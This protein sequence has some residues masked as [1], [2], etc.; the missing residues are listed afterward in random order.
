MTLRPYFTW[1]LL[2]PPPSSL[3]AL[4]FHP[5]QT[6]WSRRCKHIGFISTSVSLHLPIAASL[7]AF[8]RSLHA[9]LI[10]FLLSKI[11]HPTLKDVYV[12]IPRSC[13]YVTIH[14]QRGFENLSCIKGLE[15]ESLSEKDHDGRR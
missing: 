15:M 11:M 8:S 7:H 13:D 14:G 9:T 6:Y 4:S 5:L 12:L 3:T 10:H 1:S 2:H